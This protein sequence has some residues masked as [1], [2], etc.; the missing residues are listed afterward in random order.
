MTGAGLAAPRAILFDWDNTLVDTWPVIHD[1]INHTLVAMGQAQWT[2]EETRQRVRRSAREAFPELFGDRWERAREVF[3]DR[4]R[5][6]HLDSLAL[7]PGAAAM[8]ETLSDGRFY[9]G[10]V[11]NKAGEH[12]RREARHL[13]WDRYFARL[14]GATDAAADKPDAAAIALALQG[15]GIAPGPEVWF[16]GDTDIDLLCARNAGCV[17]I[18][19][20]AEPP[21]PGE[22][23]GVEPAVYLRTCEELSALVA[24]L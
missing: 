7:M 1:A 13:G 14:V 11:S 18:L 21:R 20:R 6:I 17:R 24:G 22:F 5:D 10:V 16:V 15:S 23:D 2:Y 9:L 8:L 4:F 3:Y 12:L 19:V